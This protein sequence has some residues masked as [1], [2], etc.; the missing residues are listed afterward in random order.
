[1]LTSVRNPLVKEARK[2]QQAKGRRSHQQF[3][4]E[5]THLVQEALAVGYPL[6]T[7]CA[8]PAWQQRHPQLWDQA[9]AVIPRTETVSLAVVAAMATTVNPDGV[10]AIAAY[11]QT[12][13]G[14][15]IAPPALPQLGIAVETLQ[16]PGNLGSLLRTATAAHCDGIWLTPD[17]VDPVHP[18]V[19]RASAG[20]WF[21]LPQVL[22]ADLASQLSQW[23][24]AGCQI[25]ATGSQ[26]AM[27]YWQVDLCQPTVIV[28]GNEGAGLSP[29]VQAAATDT[30]AI[31]MA[32]G[33]ESLNVGVAAAVILF[34]AQRQR[35]T[36]P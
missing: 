18:K 32:P 12:A 28:L 26:G 33:V 35:Q 4:I 30:I 29:A 16:D 24:Q 31:P 20:Q 27:P 13:F 25:L 36:R 3:L 15:D 9:I 23:Q 17:S 34:E 1:L 7:L 5:G 6:V 10:I 14:A 8:T 21:R 22:C 2:L 19:L 11:P